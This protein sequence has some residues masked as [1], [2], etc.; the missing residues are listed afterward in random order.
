MFR[1]AKKHVNNLQVSV[2]R[3]IIQ[4]LLPDLSVLKCWMF[5][6]YKEI[7]GNWYLN[8]METEHA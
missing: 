4:Y 2:C 5:L 7:F 6:D 1:F 3:F 8:P